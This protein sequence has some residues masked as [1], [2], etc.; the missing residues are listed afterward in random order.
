VHAALAAR[1]ARRERSAHNPHLRADHRDERRHA[2]L[3]GRAHGERA[4]AGR[5]RDP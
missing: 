4:N 5:S 2:A 1:N 3:L